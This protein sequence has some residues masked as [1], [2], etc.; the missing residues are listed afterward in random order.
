METCFK[1]PRAVEE[2]TCYRR[3]IVFEHS[4]CRLICLNWSQTL[5][6]GSNCYTNWSYNMLQHCNRSIA[7]PLSW[8]SST[9]PGLPSKYHWPNLDICPKAS[10][11]SG[12]LEG[13]G[14]KIW[15]L[16]ILFARI[17]AGIPCLQRLHN[18]LSWGLP[19]FEMEFTPAGT[20]SLEIAASLDQ[21]VV[22]VFILFLC[23]SRRAQLALVCHQ[24]WAP[25]GFKA[26]GPFR[27]AWMGRTKQDPFEAGSTDLFGFIGLSSFF[28]LKLPFWALVLHK[29]IYSSKKL[30]RTTRAGPHW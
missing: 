29:P 8:R 30:T 22:N 12:L 25:N 5:L 15:I 21:A 28:N 17:T 24:F 19:K 6:G 26:A 13:T 9:V 11:R 3:P 1:I 2:T 10:S 20:G 18:W 4:I 23:R 14:K 16:P 7:H 27:K